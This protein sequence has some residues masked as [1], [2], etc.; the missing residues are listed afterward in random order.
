L[1]GIREARGKN[2]L[3]NKEYRILPR[4]LGHRDKVEF[5]TNRAHFRTRARQVTSDKM[6]FEERDTGKWR[7][8]PLD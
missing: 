5:F 4:K 7:E 8:T 3:I 2:A 1:A 6:K